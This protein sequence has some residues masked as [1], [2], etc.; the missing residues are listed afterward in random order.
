MPAPARRPRPSSVPAP[1]RPGPAVSCVPTHRCRGEPRVRPALAGMALAVLLLGACAAPK[2][3][4]PPGEVPAVGVQ[5][6]RRVYEAPPAPAP[7][8]P[9]PEP[10]APAEA[11]EARPEGLPE[12]PPPPPPVDP[13]QAARE[14]FEAGDFAG[15]LELLEQAPATPEAL[16]L[17]GDALVA[18]GRYPEAVRAY[19]AAIPGG[20][21]AALRARVRSLV[22]AM[23]EADLRA[24]AAACPFCTDGGYARLRLARLALE[25]GDE[26]EALE[27]LAA[28]EADFADDPVGREAAGLRQDAEARRV[29][30]PGAYGVLLPLSGPL[31]P[32]GRGA[33]RGAIVGAGLFGDTDPGVR[34]LVADSRGDPEAAVEGVEDLA[35]RG[36]VGIVGPLKGA[37][38]VAAAA[39]A[40]ELGVPL[41]APTPARG[42]AGD[43]VYRLYVSEE[44]EMAALVAYAVRSLALRRFAILYPDTEL[45]RTY[46]DRFWDRVVAEGGEITGVEAFSGRSADAGVAIQKLTGVY[47]LTPEEI[48]E[49][50]LEE[51][52]LRLRRERE[53]LE[54][55]GVSAAEAAEAPEVDEERLAEYKPR[56]VVDFDALFLP[57]PSVQ[58]GQ[59]APLLPFHDV[60]GVTLLGIRAWNYPTLVEVGEEYVEGAVFAAEFHPELLQARQFVAEYRK[61]YGED[62]GVLEAYARDAVALLTAGGAGETR[63]SL[64]ERLDRLRDHPAVTGPLTA[65]PS[66]DLRGVAHVLT[67]RKGRIV[68]APQTP[69]PGEP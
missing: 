14:R 62:P 31:A 28:L 53:L 4:P 21:G 46:R 2:K 37:A 19:A 33:L 41:V 52:R 5:V 58:A 67:V 39:R 3:P 20:D 25:R 16:V 17:R 55:L 7:P 49:R 66:G 30:R 59:I 35:A 68:P 44:D 38:A 26:D 32:L 34:L 13:L 42:V 57:V 61:D 51:E 50:F 23:S 63:V 12:A 10:E 6:E 18:L 36:A 27:A 24:V 45:G 29:I 56:P 65:T 40:R 11:P 54:A 43:G 9:P 15:A 8:A 69:T 48:R 22:E 1:G 60:E 64:R 47:G